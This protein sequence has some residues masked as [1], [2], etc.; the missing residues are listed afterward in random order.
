MSVRLGLIATSVLTLS[1]ALQAAEPGAGL[2][3]MEVERQ[4]TIAWYEKLFKENMPECAVTAAAGAGNSIILGGRVERAADAKRILELAQMQRGAFPGELFN[5]IVVDK[6]PCELIQVDLTIVK[7]SPT[8]LQKV[9]AKLRQRWRDWA[10]DMADVNGKTET[11]GLVSAPCFAVLGGERPARLLCLL[12]NLRRA[13]AVEVLAEPRLV[14]MSGRPAN[15]LSGGEE[16]VPDG[17]LADTKVD[18]RPFGTRVQV[19]P[20]I[21]KDGNVALDIDVEITSCNEADDPVTV[22]GGSTRRVHFSA[23][24]AD[25]DMAALTGMTATRTDQSENETEVLTVLAAVHCVESPRAKHASTR[26]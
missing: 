10:F 8:K 4:K 9:D 18:Y 3:E 22:A 2:S 1:L 20:K 11:E 26:R 25:G 15:F 12:R 24:L 23:E 14:T 6:N 5:L 19:T 21:R 16:A 7:L 13:G 17:V